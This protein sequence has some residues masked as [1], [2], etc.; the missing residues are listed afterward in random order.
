MQNVQSKELLAQGKGKKFLSWAK[1][2]GESLVVFFIALFVF[3]CTASRTVTFEDSGL[4]ILASHFWGIAHPPGYPLYTFL[5]HIFSYL[6]FGTVAFRIS[7]LSC[8]LGAGSAVLCVQLIRVWTVS[9]V[10]AGVGALLIA[11]SAT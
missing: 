7:L 11:F 2:N 6:P 8:L 9:R 10:L 4:F 3:I 5:G 1:T